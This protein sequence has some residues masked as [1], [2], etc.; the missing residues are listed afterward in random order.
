M[1]ARITPLVVTLGLAVTAL[2]GS[3]ELKPAGGGFAVTMPGKAQY[4]K[5]TS[6]VPG[7]SVDIHTY[8]VTDNGLIYLVGYGEYPEQAVRGKTAKQ[9]LEGDR[10]GFVKAT[11]GKILK[12]KDISLGGNTGIEFDVATAKGAE[13]RVQEFLVGRRV[14]QVV[15]GGQKGSLAKAEGA[16]FF[17]SFRFVK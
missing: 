17:K 1:F 15:F 11:D 14:Y 4:Q 5:Q 13:M 8:L 9:V 3:M 10:D 7:G 12:Q 16:N 2:A 6:G